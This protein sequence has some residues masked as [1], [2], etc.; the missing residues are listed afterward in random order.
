[1]F[2][3]LRMEPGKR[4]STTV[5]R[6][7]HVSMAA[8]DCSD[9]T[10]NTEVSSVMLEEGEAEVPFILCNLSKEKNMQCPLDL[11]FATG[12]RITF[13]CKGAGTIH[14]SGYVHEEDEFDN[15]MGEEEEEDEEDEDAEEGLEEEEENVQST[16]NGLKKR[17]LQAKTGN[18]TKKLKLAAG[19][20]SE[21]DLDDEDD[22]DLDLE[23]LGEEESSDDEDEDEDDD[24]EVESPESV[25]S[26]P[27]KQDQEKAKKPKVNG[28]NAQPTKQEKKAGAQGKT[29]EV[30]PKQQKNQAAQQQAQK[31]TIEGGVQIKDTRVGTGAVCKP[32]QKVSVYYIGRF[33]DNNKV[34]DSSRKGNG[35]SFTVGKGDVIKG[36]DVGVVGMKVGGKRTITCPPNMAYGQ[37]GCPPTIPGNSTLTFEVE[38]RNVA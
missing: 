5:G 37:K 16:T 32:G 9:A 24:D 25:K 28:L 33:R 1:M 23:Q 36:W 20:D 22:D 6:P 29:K 27:I 4:Y 13:F 38:L 17:A 2:W 19:E 10:R 14:L 8:L 31:K 26:K 11:N 30:P 12:D 34:F 15:L 18:K 3:G 7:F 35:F 21:E